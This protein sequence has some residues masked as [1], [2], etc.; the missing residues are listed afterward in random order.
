L[1]LLTSDK[2]A[3]CVKNILT[4]FQ[5]YKFKLFYPIIIAF[6]N[7]YTIRNLET[8]FTKK[9]QLLKKFYWKKYFHYSYDL[10]GF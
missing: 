9:K 6:N 8:F 3:T 4:K 2:P 1:S 7:N 10:K 5:N